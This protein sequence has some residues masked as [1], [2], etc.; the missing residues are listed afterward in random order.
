MRHLFFVHSNITYLVAGQVIRHEQLPPADCAM[1]FARNFA[2]AD[3]PVAFAK[4]P[5]VTFPLTPKLWET[6]RKIGLV[7]AAIAAATHGEPFQLYC[8][9]TDNNLTRIAATHPQCAGL[10]YL[11]EGLSSYTTMGI[12]AK[13][14]SLKNSLL[15]YA[16]SGGR[17]PQLSFYEARY[18]QAYCIHASCFPGLP[19]KVV[20]GIPFK[21]AVGAPDLG[22]QQVLVLDALIEHNLVKAEKFANALR[23]LFDRYRAAGVRRVYFKYHPI[24]AGKPALQVFYRNLM[25]AYAGQI[26]FVELPQPLVLEDV[27]HTFANVTFTV[28]VSAVGFYARLCDQPVYSLARVVEREDPGFRKV[29]TRI[30]PVFFEV[31]ECL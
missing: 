21:Q 20:V 28:I 10:N 27:A 31:V 17:I 29:L 19:R 9:H 2:A 11:E 8:P 26:E 7:D 4:L 14:F 16:L 1:L 5:D 23:F 30:P 22:G 6:R 13:P 15:G 25:A 3:C 12:G 18:R 24:Q